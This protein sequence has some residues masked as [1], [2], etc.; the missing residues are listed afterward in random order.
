MTNSSAA[1]GWMPM[2]RSKSSLVAPMAT[3]MPMPCMI[4][5]ASSPSMCAPSTHRVRWQ[6]TSFISAF[7]PSRRLMLWRMGVKRVR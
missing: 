7:R 6:T 5:A 3:A 2:V 1:V 4:S